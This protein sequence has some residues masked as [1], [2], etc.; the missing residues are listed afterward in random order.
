MTDTRRLAGAYLSAMVMAG[1]AWGVTL[2]GDFD[3]GSLDEANSS[4]NGS[5]VTLA[6]RDNFYPGDWKWLHFS[7]ADVA[8]QQLFFSIDDDFSSGSSRLSDHEMVY[9]YDG[10]SWSFFDHN[11]LSSGTYSFWNDGAF[12]EETVYVAYGVPY[13]LGKVAAHTAS[14]ASSPWVSPT[15]SGDGDFVIGQSTGGVDDL[16]RVI[17]PQDLYAYKITDP[18]SEAV[19]QK[20]VF[21]SGVHPNETP[22]NH[23][24][25][26]L[27]DFLVSDDPR[28][29]ALR[30]VAEFYIYPMLNPDGRYAG[31]NRSTVEHMDRDPNRYWNEF[32]YDDMKDM[33]TV[34]EAMK[35][36]TGADVDYFIDLHSYTDTEEHFAYLDISEG[37]AA[38]PFWLNFVPLE[39]VTQTRNASVT[40]WTGMRFGRDRM[41]AEFYTTLETEFI[42]GWDGDRFEAYGANM[43]LAFAAALATIVD[44]RFDFEDADGTLLTGVEN[45]Y[46]TTVFNSPING[47][48]V[49][50]GVLRVEKPGDDF[51]SSYLDIPN[52]D[53][54]VLYLSFAIEG[55]HF[56]DYDAGEQEELRLG[57]LDSDGGFGSTITAQAQLTRVG[58]G[59]VELSSQAL[60]SGSSLDATRAY[61]AELEGL[62]TIVIELDLDADAY[63]I[64]TRLGAGA[65]E[66]LGSVPASVDPARDANAIRLVIN[67]SFGGLGEYLDLDFISLSEMNPMAGVVGDLDGSGSLDAADLVLLEVAIAEGDAN[68]DLTGDDAVTAA[69]GAFW[70]TELFG[71]LRGDVNL[72]G[73]VDLLDLSLLASS[74]G[75]AGGHAEGDL[76]FSGEVDL[77]DLSLLA[78]DFGQSSV[79]EPAG[80]AMLGLCG[81]GLWRRG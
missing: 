65:F 54:G 1:S 45:S 44:E 31:L 60:G 9:S 62:L 25:E 77:L 21:S 47:V 17:A 81:V 12:T 18:D 67:N 28:A 37:L 27:V 26:G 11:Q 34:A 55:W 15:A 41:N 43:G 59:V 38:D 69:D 6:G 29:A 20:I 22:A 68:L 30:E 56:T 58:E 80:V 49:E 66:P 57:F 74:F 3:S 8:G 63:Q 73:S 79:P 16:G 48:T 72:D 4:V 19:K 35:A 40:N 32:L 70:I 36:D 2:S 14:L 51:A 10:E 71:T 61:P 78:S 53:E 64:Y 76:D 39:P 52:L 7:A 75:G 33:K 5:F 24:L 42:P 13:S 46:G 50:D 23:V